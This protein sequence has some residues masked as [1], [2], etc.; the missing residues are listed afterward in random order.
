MHKADLQWLDGF[1]DADISAFTK[2]KK[3]IT[4]KLIFTSAL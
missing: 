1:G 2:K 3:K 4:A